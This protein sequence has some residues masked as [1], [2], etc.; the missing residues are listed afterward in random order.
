MTKGIAMM[1]MMMMTMVSEDT[2][3]E[4]CRHPS[5]SVFVISG[6][7]V[8]NELHECD[9]KRSFSHWLSLNVAQLQNNQEK[10][11]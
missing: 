3:A 2:E 1:M 7:S 6:P 10:V 8:H 4:K 11:C 5:S 9:R